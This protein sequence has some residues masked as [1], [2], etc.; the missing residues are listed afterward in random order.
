VTKRFVVLDS[1]LDASI[2]LLNYHR[3]ED[4]AYRLIL[5]DYHFWNKNE[6]AIHRWLAE[7]KITF[8]MQGMVLMF[9]TESD[10]SAFLLRW[11]G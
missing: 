2:D 5:F 9:T 4:A 1:S 10:R 3:S 8:M 11:Q 7:S 6:K